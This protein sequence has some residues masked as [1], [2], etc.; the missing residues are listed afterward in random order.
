VFDHVFHGI[1]GCV[2]VVVSRHVEPQKVMRL[3]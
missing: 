3:L 1:V 2:S